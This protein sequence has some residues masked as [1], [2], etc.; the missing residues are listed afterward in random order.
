M[1]LLT[2]I[3]FEV[4]SSP[5]SNNHKHTKNF[6]EKN[7]VLCLRKSILVVPLHRFFRKALNQ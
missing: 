1:K 3:E 5:P 6:T 4:S 2:F 7:I